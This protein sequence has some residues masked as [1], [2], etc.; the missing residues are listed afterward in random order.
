M[1]FKKYTLIIPNQIKVEE[2]G[3][4]TNTEF[5]AKSWNRLTIL[6]DTEGGVRAWFG[7]QWKTDYYSFNVMNPLFLGHS[8]IECKNTL[9]PR[10]SF[11]FLGLDMVPELSIFFKITTYGDKQE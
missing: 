1:K 11:T 9:F 4:L 6:Y 2:K 5:K 10:T 8:D 7:F 3:N